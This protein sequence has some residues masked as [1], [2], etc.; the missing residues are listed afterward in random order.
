MGGKSGLPAIM[1]E[2]V[3]LIRIT[4]HISGWLFS[5]YLLV[6]DMFLNDVCRDAVQA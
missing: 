3:R 1:A 5:V 4:L 2:H 6:A